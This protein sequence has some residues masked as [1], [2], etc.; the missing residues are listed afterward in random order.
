M[1]KQLVIIG[2]TLILITVGLSGCDSTKQLTGQT[3]DQIIIGTWNS[4]NIGYVTFYTNHS[5][6]IITQSYLIWGEYEITDDQ[7]FLTYQ[8]QT[9]V[10]QYSFTDNNNKLVGT[11]QNGDPAVFTRVDSSEIAD[12][13]N[14][15]VINIYDA[16][17]NDP[18]DTTDIDGD[19]IGDNADKYPNDSTNFDR[20]RLAGT[21]INSTADIGH[22]FII[23]SEPVTLWKADGNW[24]NQYYHGL[25]HYIYDLN[26]SSLLFYNEYHSSRTYTFTFMLFNNDQTLAL[27]GTW[28]NVTYIYTRQ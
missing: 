9:R 24:S 15:G 10:F 23:T 16:F 19:G 5:L 17:P 13:D 4:E 14:D 27:T 20:N 21:W 8:S 1:K 11:N 2:I 12:S 22:T 18:T 6:K 28:N 25:W 26:Q 7:L 3:P